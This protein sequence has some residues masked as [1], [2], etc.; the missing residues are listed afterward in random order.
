MFADIV[1]FLNKQVSEILQLRQTHSLSF[2]PRQWQ[3][4]CYLEK[5]RR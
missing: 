5:M 3:A 2:Q 1:N 4:V